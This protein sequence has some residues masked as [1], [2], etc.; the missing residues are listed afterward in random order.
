MKTNRIIALAAALTVGLGGLTAIPASAATKCEG[1]TTAGRCITTSNPV[2]RST[3]VESVPLINASKTKTVTMSCGFSQTITRTW[4][5]SATLSAEVKAKVWGVV[6]ATVGGSQTAS[7]SQTASAATTAGGSVTLKPGESV[8]C[9]RIYGYYTMTT[10]ISTWTASK[11]L[12]EQRFT[13]T[14]PYSLGVK[15]VD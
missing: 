9:Q 15:I 6:E 4:G 7:L 5:V 11:S 12:P 10:V 13:S 8:T 14:L 3:V 1:G 2:Y